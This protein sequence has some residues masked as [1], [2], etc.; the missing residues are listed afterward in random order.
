MKQPE[1]PELLNLLSTYLKYSIRT[2]I[3]RHRHHYFLESLHKKNWT[4]LLRENGFVQKSMSLLEDLI[5]SN[6]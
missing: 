6:R 2:N 4:G 1:L 3:I 5:F